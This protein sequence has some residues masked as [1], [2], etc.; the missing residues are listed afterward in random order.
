MQSF[1]FEEVAAAATGL[2]SPDQ[3]DRDEDRRLLIQQTVLMQARLQWCGVDM[4]VPPQRNIVAIGNLTE[5]RQQQERAFRKCRFLPVVAKSDRAKWMREARYFLNKDPQRQY[6]RYA[7]ITCGER[8]PFGPDF[9]EKAEAVIAKVQANIRRWASDG[10]KKYDVDVLL[11]TLEAALNPESAHFHFNIVF[12]PRRRLSKPEHARWL[13]WTKRRLGGVHWK[14]CGRI[15]DLREVIKYSCKLQGPESLEALDNRDFLSMFGVMHG[16]STIEAHGSFAEFRRDLE[17]TKKRVV[18]LR[19]RNA[20][21][22]LVIMKKQAKAP[23]NDSITP[24]NDVQR[25]NVILGRQLPR[26]CGKPVLEPVTLVQNYT[27]NPTTQ[28]GKQGLAI[29]Q[30]HVRQAKEWGQT[31]GF[32]NVHT[33]PAS[34]QPRCTSE[35]ESTGLSPAGDHPAGDGSRLRDRPRPQS[36]VMT[37]AIIP[38]RRTAGEMKEARRQRRWQLEET[39]A[40]R[41]PEFGKRAPIRRL[42]P[43]EIQQRIRSVGPAVTPRR[44]TR[45]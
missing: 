28:E 38:K 40:G 4:D 36:S 44:G 18:W 42:T 11:K 33:T 31:N 10:R 13:T 30:E 8:I 41:P 29:I 22:R 35:T 12:I 23:K 27:P 17:A 32:F 19:Q 25:E 37:T 16:R 20:P 39:R 43:Q 1:D 14:D 3:S 34:V 7:V 9:V 26:T 45:T 2:S 24:G 15:R 21:P 6:A 5:S